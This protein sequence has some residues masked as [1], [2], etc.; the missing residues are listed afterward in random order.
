M[1]ISAGI[2]F[3]AVLL[4]LQIASAVTSPGFPTFGRSVTMNLAFHI[5]D[6]KNDDTITYTDNYISSHDAG[7]VLALVSNAAFGTR[8]SELSEDYLLEMR[9]PLDNRFYLTFTKGNNQTI[10]NKT[11]YV[12][13]PRT[14]GNLAMPPGQF[15]LYLRLEYSDIDIINRV[16]WERGYREIIISNEGKNEKGQHIVSIELIK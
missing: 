1:R 6:N 9:Q 12:I 5:G 8:F 15:P 16:R 4:I 14:F 7:V 11:K 3:I 10:A 2:L 13:V